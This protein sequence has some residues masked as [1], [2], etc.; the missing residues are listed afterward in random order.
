MVMFASNDKEN[1][2]LCDCKDNVKTFFVCIDKSNSCG[3]Q[4]THNLFVFCYLY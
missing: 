1:W 2:M 4:Q 3:K